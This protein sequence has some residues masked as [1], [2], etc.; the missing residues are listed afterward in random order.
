MSLT[1][2]MGFMCMSSQT[3]SLMKSVSN[4]Y[5]ISVRYNLFS[6]KNGLPQGMAVYENDCCA[7]P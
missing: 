5:S 3:F 4:L 2:S 7:G 1:K 6:I